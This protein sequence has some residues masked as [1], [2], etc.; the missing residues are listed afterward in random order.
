MQKM[1]ADPDFAEITNARFPPTSAS[2][3]EMLGCE[4]E[5]R[6]GFFKRLFG[7]GDDNNERQRRRDE[8]EEDDGKKKKGF[9]KRLFGKKDDN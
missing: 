3:R 9:F 4:P 1:N 8:A 7:G 6:D 5:Q 2:V